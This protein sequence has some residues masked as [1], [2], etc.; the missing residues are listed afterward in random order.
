MTAKVTIPSHNIRLCESRKPRA[1][2]AHPFLVPILILAIGFIFQSLW[3]NKPQLISLFNQFRAFSLIENP[4]LKLSFLL[5]PIIVIWTAEAVRSKSRNP[6]HRSLNLSIFKNCVPSNGAPFSD[7]FYFIFSSVA[8]IKPA[9]GIVATLGLSK[10]LSEM[11][12]PIGSPIKA[13][14]SGVSI[15]NPVLELFIGALVFDFASYLSHRID[16]Q[17]RVGWAAHE[18]HH[19]AKEMNI[20]NYF[21]RS[22]YESLFSNIIVMPITIVAANF[23]NESLDK[24]PVAG[25]ILLISYTAISS[26]NNWVGHSNYF[27][28]YN[29]TISLFFMSPSHHW[30]HHSKDP[31]HLNK[32]FGTVFVFWDKLFGTFADVDHDMAVALVY[33]VDGCRYESQNLLIDYFVLPLVLTVTELR[34]W[35]ANLLAR[36]K[37]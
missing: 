16:H 12:T 4:L 15:Q 31:T 26:F 5:L 23:Y 35:F 21:R 24:L 22:Q 3:I 19:S 7:L 36:V 17:W 27:F 1:F 13:L 34:L 20:F 9:I 28:K 32:N 29:K 33:G 18:F 8:S 11:T 30:V 37:S 14:I 2:N 6:Y 10:I 25:A